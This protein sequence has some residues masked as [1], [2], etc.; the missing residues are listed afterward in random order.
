MSFRNPIVGGTSLV[1][2]AIQSPNFQSGVQ[3]WQ[4][5]RNGSAEFAN[6]SIDGNI[7]AAQ[8]TAQ[9]FNVGPGGLYLSDG[10]EALADIQALQAFQTG[11]ENN[12]VTTTWPIPGGIWMGGNMTYTSIPSAQLSTTGEMGI[13]VLNTGVHQLP[14]WYRVV[15][16]T[17]A[18]QPSASVTSWRSWSALRGTYAYSGATPTAPT[19]SS[20]MYAQSAVYDTPSTRSYY[21]PGFEHIWY[22][23]T[24]NSMTWNWLW[25]YGCWNNPSGDTLKFLT[26]QNYNTVCFYEEYLGNPFSDND[27]QPGMNG[28]GLSWNAGGGSVPSPQPPPP[29]PPTTHSKTYYFDW[30]RSFDGYGDRLTNSALNDNYLYQG[31]GGITSSGNCKS[32]F[33]LN[34][35]DAADI[36]SRLTGATNISMTLYW[37]PIHTYDYAGA[38]WLVGCCDWTSAPSSWSWS[39]VTTDIWTTGDY[40]PGDNAHVNVSS[41]A[42]HFASGY[43]TGFTFGPAPDSS[44]ASYKYWAYAYQ[45]GSGNGPYLSITYTK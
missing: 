6:L 11:L 25:T 28:N 4:V 26:N 32:A 20:T 40:A 44:S 19:V 30:S 45:P 41:Q 9:Q 15:V 21:I 27:N 31:G 35:S 5:N 24:S 7:N 37:S 16:D 33:G 42:S 43:Y 13:A 17:I 38:P 14:G 10:S 34:A 2:N 12:E 23:S 29:P 39:D 18:V 8:L 3:G 36:Q 1:I 22:T